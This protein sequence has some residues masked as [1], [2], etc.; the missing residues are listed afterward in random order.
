[1]NK[2]CV[3]Q[4]TICIYEDILPNSKK[5]Q[6]PLPRSCTH[7]ADGEHLQINNKSLIAN[8]EQAK[9][10]IKT[11]GRF[12][13]NDL[14][15]SFIEQSKSD[16]L[17]WVHRQETC[18]VYFKTLSSYILLDC[19]KKNSEK[20]KHL[21]WQ[22]SN[23]VSPAETFV[24]HLLGMISIFNYIWTVKHWSGF[25]LLVYQKNNNPN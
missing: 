14:K 1:M 8:L 11:D 21:Y 13:H 20:W 16:V 17:Q 25:L 4:H 7:V 18:F 6:S 24:E 15:G 9:R 10:C 23:K 2:G 22:D 19:Q 12:Q 5:E 3:Q